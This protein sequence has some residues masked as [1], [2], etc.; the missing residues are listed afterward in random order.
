MELKIDR[1]K[2]SFI[3]L[4]KGVFLLNMTLLPSRFAFAV[5]TCEP[6]LHKDILIFSDSLVFKET[7][8][9]VRI[10]Q[11]GDLYL[12]VK[13]LALDELQRA[14]LSQYN[15]MIRFDFSYLH[16]LF[17]N[18]IKATWAAFDRIIVAE[19]GD[20]SSLGQALKNYHIELL[21]KID[22]VLVDQDK[23]P[24]LDHKALREL[25]IELRASLPIFLQM[26]SVQG[27]SDIAQQS[28]GKTNKL[29]YMSNK[30]NR[31]QELLTK[32][33]LV[34]REQ[35]NK[36]YQDVCQRLLQWQAQ[37]QIISRLVPALADLKTV[38]LD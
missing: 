21:Q 28:A 38:T 12:N 1:K 16:K 3:F 23:R 35:G 20:N 37:E 2:A 18:Q 7:D 24:F 6:R 13:P 32:E 22:K 9:A 29:A 17:Q 14:F 15:Q 27:L 25:Q 36:L 10:E 26:I 8:N 33:I 4:L 19:L 34:Q 31:L 5:P 30:L 11:D